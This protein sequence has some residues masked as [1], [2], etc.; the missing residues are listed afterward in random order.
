MGYEAFAVPDAHDTEV[1]D[2]DTEGRVVELDQAGRVAE[3]IAELS[4]DD[5]A[6]IILRD[7]EGLST[8]DTATVLGISESAAKVR[9]HRAHARLREAMA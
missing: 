6:V 8:R 2:D 7:I 1:A 9:L 3:A 4:E 5:R